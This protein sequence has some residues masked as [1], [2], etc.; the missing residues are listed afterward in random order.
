MATLVRARIAPLNS[1]IPTPFPREQ[2]A[3]NSAQEPTGKALIPFEVQ[4]AGTV[5]KIPENEASTSAL[6]QSGIATP[7][8]YTLVRHTIPSVFCSLSNKLA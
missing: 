4:E 8:T 1:P 3:Q 2:L 5:E 7:N 6:T